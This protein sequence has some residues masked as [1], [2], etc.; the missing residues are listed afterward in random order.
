VFLAVRLTFAFFLLCSFAALAGDIYRHRTAD[1]RTIFTDSASLPQGAVETLR[2][3]SSGHRPAVP[4][5]GAPQSRDRAHAEIRAAEAELMQ[6]Y[7]RLTFGVKPREDEIL[8]F[9][10]EDPAARRGKRR[11]IPKTPEYYQR[12]ELLK[13]DITRAQARLD[14]ARER[15]YASK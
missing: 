14:D 8:P 6:A 13:A 1:G 3:S 15:F 9:A 2:V 7:G 10:E 12:V 11:E 5:P 4:V